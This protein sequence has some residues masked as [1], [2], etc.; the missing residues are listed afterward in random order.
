MFNKKH[1][2]S[3][4][5]LFLFCFSLIGCSNKKEEQTITSF[6]D[7][8]KSVKGTTVNFYGWGGSNFTNQWIDNVLAKKVKEDYDITLKRV[9]MDIDNILNKLIG[10]K[11]GGKNTEGSIDLVW[12][13]GENFYSAKKA[14][15][16]YGPFTDKLPNFQKYINPEDVAYDFGYKTD[17]YESPYGKAQLVMV[18]NEEFVTA[19]PKDHKELLELCK[20]YPGKFTYA[21]PPD[22]TGSAFVR[23]IVFD[24]VGPEKIMSLKD[25]KEEVK[26][27]IAPALDYLKELKPYLWNN[28]KTY[29]ATTAQLDN[30]FADKQVIGTMTYSP[31]SIEGKINNGEYPAKAKASIFTKG[32][33]GNTHFVAIPFN[34]PNKAGAMA[35]ANAIL[36]VDMQASKYDPVTWGDL[37]VLDNSKLSS[38][39][40]DIFSKVKISSS[41]VPQEELSAHKYSEPPAYLIPIIEKLWLETIPN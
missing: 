34:A 19:M 27:V 10:E 3:L 9:P 15:L 30:M 25:D 7:V 5:I 13:N 38:E 18:F 6:D 28:G 21:A 37:P 31:N 29:P 20:K 17:G 16:L 40:K 22:F 33:I 24:I 12:L 4:S 32:A 1:W 23:N 11:Q 14:N 26:R 35:V 36:S 39:E 8:Q 41:T 2:F